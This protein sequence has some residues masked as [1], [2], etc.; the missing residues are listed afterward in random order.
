MTLKLCRY[1][2][3]G[4]RKEKMER[5]LCNTNFV[6]AFYNLSKIRFHNWVLLSICCWSTRHGGLNETA[7]LALSVVHCSLV[8]SS[9]RNDVKLAHIEAYLVVTQTS[10]LNR[11]DP[12]KTTV[13]P[14]CFCIV[15][16]N[17]AIGDCGTS[18]RFEW[19]KIITSVLLRHWLPTLGN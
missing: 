1:W 5:G 15:F 8:N 18:F 9:L 12:L 16:T 7:Y 17:S 3:I 11:T 19:Y 2:D 13:C 10:S 4:M 14:T 6:K